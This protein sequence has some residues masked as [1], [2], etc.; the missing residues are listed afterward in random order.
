MVT[1][2]PLFITLHLISAILEGHGTAS[3]SWFV[4][5]FPESQAKGKVFMTFDRVYTP[6]GDSHE[7]HLF[8]ICIP[9]GQA[10]IFR[11]NMDA[12]VQPRCSN[13]AVGG[14]E[15]CMVISSLFDIYGCSTF[16]KRKF[17]EANLISS[18][19][20]AG[21]WIW[22]RRR[23]TRLD[24]FVSVILDEAIF[25]RLW[26]IFSIRYTRKA[27]F[28]GGHEPRAIVMDYLQLRYVTIEFSTRF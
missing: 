1:L 17:T 2:S 4:G 20:R 7:A 24:G 8:C 19:F 25:S 27:Q 16:Y 15:H 26:S 5:F 6:T 22:R 14:R 18:S 3:W 28:L 12:V 11:S 13:E 10:D 9:R 23:T 21:K